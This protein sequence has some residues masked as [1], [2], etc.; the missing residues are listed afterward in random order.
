MGARMTKPVLLAVEAALAAAL[1]KRGAENKAQ[2]AEG[3][4]W[5]RMERR[6]REKLV[7]PPPTMLSRLI[8]EGAH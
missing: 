3:L 8:E 7:A 6:R 5:V 4:E 2:L 1:K